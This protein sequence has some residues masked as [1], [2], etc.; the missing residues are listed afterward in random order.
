LRTKLIPALA[1]LLVAPLLSACA[2]EASSTPVPEVAQAPTA[3]TE[4]A[5]EG[6]EPP[7][8]DATKPV[9]ATP[10]PEPTETPTIVRQAKPIPP[11]AG[12]P[13]YDFELTDLDGNVIRLSSLRGKKVMLNFWATWCGPC[14]MEIPHMVELYDEKGNAELEI[15]AVNVNEAPD[16]VRTFVQQND[17]RFPVPL[18]TKGS[19]A[20]SYFVRAIPTSLF[21]DEQGIIVAVHV[22]TLTEQTLQGYIQQLFG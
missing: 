15:L 22:G 5:M 13:A 8:T 9:A 17:M 14:R 4:L 10:I 3:T 12:D 2:P 6:P 16:K 1:L 20:G 19:I 7:P 21:I 11:K 18:D